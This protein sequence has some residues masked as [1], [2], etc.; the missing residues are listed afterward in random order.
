[1]SNSHISP[2][3]AVSSFKIEGN[4]GEFLTVVLLDTYT[5]EKYSLLSLKAKQI[6]AWIASREPVDPHDTLLKLYRIVNRG[7]RP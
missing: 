3:F 2:R 6:A 5:Q 1:M 4:K 7:N